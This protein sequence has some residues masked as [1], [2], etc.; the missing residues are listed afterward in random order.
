MSTSLAGYSRIT[1]G[2]NPMTPDGY[3][4]FYGIPPESILFWMCTN[5][6]SEFTDGEELKNNLMKTFK[7]V[8][9]LFQWDVDYSKIILGIFHLKNSKN[10][11]MIYNTYITW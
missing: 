9:E 1:G 8:H 6:Q 7:E 10:I 3:G 11:S 2:C 5:S 4:I